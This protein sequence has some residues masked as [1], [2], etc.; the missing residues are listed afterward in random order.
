MHKSSI[1]YPLDIPN[2]PLDMISGQTENSL[3]GC[4][5]YVSWMPPDNLGKSDISHYIVY[6]NE[7][8]VKNATDHNM[9]MINSTLA[10]M[11]FHVCGCEAHIVG[12]SAVNRC[13]QTGQRIHRITTGPEL[14][15]TP[16]CKVTTSNPMDLNGRIM[17]FHENLT[18]N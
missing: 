1:V 8:N 18:L 6:D 7:T 2:T 17:I 10:M 15:S 4:T 12:V 9:T 14:L 13:G 5:V 3:G 11:S 16:S